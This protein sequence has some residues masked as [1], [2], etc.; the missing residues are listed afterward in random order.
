MNW[1]KEAGDKGFEELVQRLAE[2]ARKYYD[3]LPTGYTPDAEDIAGYVMDQLMEERS[4]FKT[5]KEYD[6]FFNQ[7]YV[8]VTNGEEVVEAGKKGA[9]CP[10]C[11]D[12]LTKETDPDLKKEYPWACL[13]CDENFYGIEVIDDPEQAKWR[14]ENLTDKEKADKEYARQQRDLDEK[15]K[16]KKDEKAK[17]LFG[18]G[19]DSI[20]YEQQQKVR[21]SLGLPGD[22]MD[23]KKK[24]DIPAKKY[25]VVI[26]VELAYVVD[27]PDEE[28]A[29]QTIENIELPK[30]YVED[31]FNIVKVVEAT[32]EDVNLYTVTEFI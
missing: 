30:Y 19:W 25:K 29:K 10:K 28:I 13:E 6:D 15:E 12:P 21:E 2:D 24:A 23:W 8:I 9:W 11:G 17:E 26:Q 5:V 14:R 27:A 4:S 20:S 1:V 22:T 32:P 18:K 3:S 31:T 16:V 7:I